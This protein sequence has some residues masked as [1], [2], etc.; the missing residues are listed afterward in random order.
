MKREVNFILKETK[1]LQ[2]NA[3]DYVITVLGTQY[4]FGLNHSE[5]KVTMQPSI[6]LMRA[7]DLDKVTYEN[8]MRIIL[9]L[10]ETLHK[11]I[12]HTAKFNRAYNLAEELAKVIKEL[13]DVES[14]S[15]ILTNLL[16]S[17]TDEEDRRLVKD[18][19]EKFRRNQI[20]K[21][22]MFNEYSEL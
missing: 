17:I 19:L 7:F 15:T 18:R 20:S 21:F 9:E 12:L 16:L 22:V 10:N 11:T 1:S 14:T 2:E 8:C 13:D 6:N 5:Q 3:N 4:K